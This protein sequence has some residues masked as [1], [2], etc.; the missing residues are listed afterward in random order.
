MQCTSDA[1]RRLSQEGP[2]WGKTLSDA[3]SAALC[4]PGP[5][6]RATGCRTP[7]LASDTATPAVGRRRPASRA[8]DS[9]GHE[10]IERALVV[11]DV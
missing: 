5:S 10:A 4:P 6:I 2:S 7:V 8:S 1:V 9:G 3:L 11:D